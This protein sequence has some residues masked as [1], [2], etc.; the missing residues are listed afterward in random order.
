MFQSIKAVESKTF[1]LFNLVFVSDTILSCFIFFFLIIEFF[2]FFF[3]IPAVITQIFNPTAELVIP[4][5]VQTK[6][7]KAKMETHSVTVK[8]K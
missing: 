8:T 7:A 1:T 4:T 5:A 2:L 6:G 3:F